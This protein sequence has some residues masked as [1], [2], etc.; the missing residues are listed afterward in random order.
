MDWEVIELPSWRAYPADNPQR[1]M[2]SAR[3]LAYVIYTSGSTGQPKGVMVEHR[4][5]VQPCRL[6]CRNRW[7]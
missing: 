5:V 7:H 3:H 6:D 1:P 4:N 2:L